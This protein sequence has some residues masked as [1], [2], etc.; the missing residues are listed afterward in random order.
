MLLPPLF[1]SIPQNIP[2]LNSASVC[3]RCINEKLLDENSGQIAICRILGP[4]YSPSRLLVYIYAIFFVEEPTRQTFGGVGELKSS[5][6][7]LTPEPKKRNSTKLRMEPNPAFAAALAIS[8]SEQRRTS[9]KRAAPEST[10]T[11]AMKTKRASSSQ[12]S[13][14]QQTALP[15]RSTITAPSI[16]ASP[17]SPVDPPSTNLPPPYPSPKF[18]YGIIW[19]EGVPPQISR[20]IGLP[21]CFFEPKEYD[22]SKLEELY[23]IELHTLRGAGLARALVTLNMKYSRQADELDKV[24]L[25]FAE[26]VHKSDKL[27]STI[28]EY[29]QAKVREAEVARSKMERELKK[30]KEISRKAILELNQLRQESLWDKKTL[31]Q[32]RQERQEHL[33]ELNTHIAAVRSAQELIKI[34]DDAI[35]ESVAESFGNAIAQIKLLNPNISFN[36]SRMDCMSWVRHGKIVP[37]FPPSDDVPDAH[38]E[39]DEDEDLGEET[40]EDE[41]EDVGKETDEDEDEDVGEETDASP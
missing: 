31:E 33:A 17:E 16:D 38:L 32:Y 9:A 28:R 1:A 26:H 23:D 19:D 20:A 41:D 14:V 35:K 3:R 21:R 39:E 4:I 11:S 12:K 8:G 25:E 13:K 15:S 18:P 2:T 10:S 22:T 7:I 34:K 30:E 36:T 27:T 6:Y 24:K 5:D 29:A 40:D 37:L